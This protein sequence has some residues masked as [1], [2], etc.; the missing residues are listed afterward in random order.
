MHRTWGGIVAGALFVLPSLFILIALSWV[1]MAFGHLSWV[2]GLLYGIKPAVAALVL[3]AVHR[4]GGR[5][6]RRPAQAP[7]LWALAVGS[8]VAVAWLGLP[9]PGV[10]LA[11][12][13]TGW[14]GARWAPAQFA[15]AGGHGAAK[16]QHTHAPALI[17]DDTPTPSHARFSRWG[18]LRVLL[19]GAVLWLAPM[20]LLLAW[21]GAAG[22][23]A[24][25]GW[26]FSKARC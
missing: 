21:Q 23:L 26:F 12:A 14:V 20:G 7:L 18:L 4:I 1:Y 16:E 10:V 11:A 22:T 13:L 5:T 17:D 24:Q 25:M 15:G 3:Q 2:A 6:L 8:F 19:A 9:F